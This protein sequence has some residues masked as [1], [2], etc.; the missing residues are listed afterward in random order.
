VPGLER[1]RGRGHGERAG[2]VVVRLGQRAEVRRGETGQVTAVQADIRRAQVVGQGAG[3]GRGV[4]QGQ[5]GH[6]GHGQG[7]GDESGGRRATHMRRGRR[8]RSGRGHAVVRR[9]AAAEAAGPRARETA[10]RAEKGETRHAHTGPDHGLVHR[11]LVPVLLHVHTDAPVPDVPHTAA[12]V[13]HSVLAGLHELGHQPGHLHDIQQGLP[14]QLPPRAVQIDTSYLRRV[15]VPSRKRRHCRSRHQRAA[16]KTTK[17]LSRNYPIVP[18]PQLQLL[19]L[20]LLT[21]SYRSTRCPC[22]RRFRHNYYF[23]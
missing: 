18:L 2:T 23:S 15:H 4:G 10:D 17:S 13:H 7:V 22:H 6:A 8:G 11:L 14:P 19:L 9:P 3:R 21:I 1:G 12:G 16:S 20:L 5:A